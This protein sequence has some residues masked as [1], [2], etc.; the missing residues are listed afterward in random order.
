MKSVVHFLDNPDALGQVVGP[1]SNGKTRP[2]S[3]S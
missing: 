1:G 3:L 2:E